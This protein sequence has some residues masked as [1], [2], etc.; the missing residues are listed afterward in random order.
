M[1]NRELLIMRYIMQ[2]DDTNLQMNNNNA[3]NTA[4]AA[5]ES[6]T[7]HV[8]IL[9]SAA[10][11][12]DVDVHVNDK[13]V[14]T[15]LKYREFT[16]YM[17]LPSGTYNFKVYRAGDTS[18]PLVDVDAYI[19]PASISTL[20]AHTDVNTLQLA[21]VEERPLYN[22][23]NSKAKIR[24]VHLIENTPPVDLLIIENGR[25]FETLDFTDIADYIEIPPGTYTLDVRLAD[26]DI[27]LLY[28]PNATLKAGNYY[29][30]YLIGLLND[31]PE[32]QVL[33][34]LDGLSYINKKK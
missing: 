4:N 12:P 26:T 31:Y 34:P 17:A 10:K 1:I 27:S 14:A 18:K 25:I 23:D 9:H 19:A 5:D 22:S 7:A 29:S 8:R 20:A 6:M 33:I 24:A 3:N 15:N 30:V 28:V 21:L 32:A 13:P 2:Y 11:A 16:E